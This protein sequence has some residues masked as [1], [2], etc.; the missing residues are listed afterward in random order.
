V[1]GQLWNALGYSQAY[2]PFLIQPAR[3][4]GVYLV[5][6]LIVAINAVV[7]LLVLSRTRWTIAAA[8]LTTL[9]VALVIGDAAFSD[10]IVDYV[11]SAEDD[12]SVV[13]VQ[14]NVPLTTVKT[15]A[16]LKALRERHVT[17][18]VNGL[19]TLGARNVPELVIWPESPM[20]FEYG[21][22][23]SFREFVADFTQ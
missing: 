2:H 15:V 13:A 1:T 9:A 19:K 23:R 21:S 14:P 17:L 20:N 11:Y 10:T 4:G 18:S 12:V 5:S 3:W 7:T 6:F 22:D 8:V 16:E